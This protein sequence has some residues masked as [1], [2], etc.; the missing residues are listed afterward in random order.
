MANVVITGAS[1][2]FATAYGPATNVVSATNASP[3]VWT[4]ASGSG[5][6][7]GDFVEITSSGWGR[8]EGRIFRVSAFAADVATLEGLDTTD[9]NLFPAGGAVGSSVRRIVTWTQLSQIG[10]EI[11]IEG[12]ELETADATYIS[13]VQR[14]NIPIFRSPVSITLPVFFDPSL[15]WVAAA[16]TATLANAVRGLRAIWPGGS[17]TI[18]NGYFSYGE[19]PTTQDS[20]LRTSITVLGIALPTT[21]AT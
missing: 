7:I 12:N 19:A 18:F 16:R 1:F 3:S 11:T 6:V 20:T 10:R 14:K 17:R 5:I 21:Y 15:A 13:D 9:V 2:A 8:A 4:L